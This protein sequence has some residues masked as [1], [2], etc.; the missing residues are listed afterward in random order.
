MKDLELQ[1][2]FIE[3]LTSEQKRDKEIEKQRQ[4]EEAE[5][6][7]KTL[8]AQSHLRKISLKIENLI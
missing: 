4:R 7:R 3:K 8:E 2:N 1:R 6:Y 5:I